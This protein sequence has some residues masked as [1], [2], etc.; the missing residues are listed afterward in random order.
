MG[1][2]REPNPRNRERDTTVSFRAVLQ[3]IIGESPRLETINT[4]ADTATNKLVALTEKVLG[5]YRATV[6]SKAGGAALEDE[7]YTHF[8][9]TSL[10]DILD[11]IEKRRSELAEIDN[12]ITHLP[13]TKNILVPPDASSPIPDAGSG[14][15]EPA[16]K[17]P[18]LKALLYVLARNGIR[19][20]G[21]ELTKGSVTPDML[22]KKPY[23]SVFTP[24]LHRLILVCDEERNA[25]FIFDTSQ[26]PQNLTPYEL[27][28][29]GKDELN[30]L[31]KNNPHAGTRLVQ[32]LAWM[33]RIER[34]FFSP[35]TYKTR[36]QKTEPETDK[37]KRLALPQVSTGDLDPWKGFY[38]DPET[39]KH[40]GSIISIAAR[41]NVSKKLVLVRIT[42]HKLI[43]LRARDV[44]GRILVAYA[45]EDLSELINDFLSS[46]P[47]AVEG[48]WKGFL[49]K[50]GK[51]YGSLNDLARRLQLSPKLVAAQVKAHNLRHLR[52]RGR[53]GDSLDAYA[54]E[55]ISTFL[56]DFL[57]L[58]SVA[59]EGEWKHFFEKN[60]KHWGSVKAIARKL[61]VADQ[62]ITSPL[63]LLTTL[64]VRNVGGKIVDAYA[65]EDVCAH[66]NDVLSLPAV[67][68]RGEWKGFCEKDNEHYGSI[69]SLATRLG[70][71]TTLVTARIIEHKPV[72][73]R[74]RDLTGKLREVYSFEDVQN[75]LDIK[76]KPASTKKE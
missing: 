3:D 27:V 61:N 75:L 28:H 6:H 56:E 9:L 17:L 34:S 22:R 43:T 23:V 47:V 35:I 76:H 2:F 51:H 71:S 48:P 32:S 72:F 33:E 57:S 21:I 54:F 16:G 19:I 60:G 8:K 55:D 36:T 18:R 64:R 25:T 39:G 30:T 50:D 26:L 65:F 52:V 14:T 1:E 5:K 44:L 69:H 13:I 20:E 12:V 7:A 11:L 15:Y 63:R 42:T 70:L 74:A 46:P 4:F 59:A 62:T 10:S 38:T 40:Y 68:A 49:E 45:F 41:F 37:Q 53:G 31:I 66:L 73:L 67:A 29:F 24:S 58:S